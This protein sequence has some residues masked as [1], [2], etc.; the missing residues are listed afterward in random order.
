VCFLCAE[1]GHYANK[2]PKKQLNNTLKLNAN[3]NTS[4]PRQYQAPGCNGNQ[5][6]APNNRAQQNYARG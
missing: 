4:R 5:A 6:P 1:E 3:G 2:F